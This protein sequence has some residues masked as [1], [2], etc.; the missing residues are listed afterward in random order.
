MDP[1]SWA[2]LIMSAISTA[3]SLNKPDIETE[4]AA[5][6]AGI[7]PADLGNI[8]SPP[9]DPLAA[10]SG[11]PQIEGPA[12]AAA[13]AAAAVPQTKVTPPPSVPGPVAKAATPGAPNVPAPTPPAKP[14]PDIGA[15][16]AAVP[17]ALAAVAP[18]LGL[19]DQNVRTSR[20]APIS[21][22]N[23]GSRIGALGRQTAGI[24]I[25]QLLAAL[26]GIR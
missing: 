18:L 1:F 23:A 7:N 26:P 16:L 20:P 19:T 5:P 13:K 24:D 17:D 22:V 2:M 9:S 21:G 12:N 8:I 14:P 25:G 3:S 6:T 4:D 10:V 11:L 15:V